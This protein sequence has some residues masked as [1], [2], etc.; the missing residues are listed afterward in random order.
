[1]QKLIAIVGPTASGKTALATQLALHFNGELVSADA[2]Q[3]F[4][5]MDIGTAKEKNLPVLQHLLDIREPGERIAVGE[6]QTLAYVAIDEILARGK[7]PFLVGGSG[8]YAE[9]V[10]H[11]YR[12]GGAGQKQAEPRYQ[13]LELALE[14]DREE[15]CQR[16]AHRT[17]KWLE[18]GLLAEIQ[19]LLDKG[20]RRQWLD[21]CGLEYRY[22]TAHLLGEL[23]LQQASQQTNQAL[24][25]FVKRQYTWWRRHPELV[26]VRDLAEAEG[27][28]K[29]FL[30]KK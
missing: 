27:R 9:A 29:E 22:F 24:N 26:W 13:V 14:V 17:Q 5:G 15:L 30:L 3:V 11:G 25:Q 2:K 19:G 12:F 10:T 21:S 28:V 20:V 7:Q 6:Y 1:M 16:L 23:S 18:Q 8:L 4:R